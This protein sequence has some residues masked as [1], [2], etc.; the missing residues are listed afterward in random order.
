MTAT[1]NYF[2]TIHE[3]REWENDGVQVHNDPAV[4]LDNPQHWVVA[5]YDNQALTLYVEH[6]TSI[7]L[8]VTFGGDIPLASER[9]FSLGLEYSY[10]WTINSGQQIAVEP[11][12]KGW[13]T[14]AV[15]TNTYDDHS[16]Y[17]TK[18]DAAGLVQR[19]VYY[20]FR[21]PRGDF[22]GYAKPEDRSGGGPPNP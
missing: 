11:L 17:A 12:K 16:G 6:S 22:L 18:W 14:Y 19:S 9:V 21:V 8:G 5:Q 3:P 2:L 20:W 10:N 4:P 15:E 1:A 13:G 7:T